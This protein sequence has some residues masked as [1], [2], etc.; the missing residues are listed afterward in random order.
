[1][2]EYRRICADIDLDAL[3]HNLDEIHRCISEG[4]K[5]IAVVKANG[6]GHG[7]VPLAEVMEK[8]ED[9]WGY[10][11]ATPEEAEELYTNGMK[12]PILILGYTF[13]EYDAQIVKEELRPAVFSLIRA[14]QLSEEALRQ[15]KI[16]KIHIKLDTG[17][18]RIGFQVTEQSADEIAQIAKLPHIMIEGIFTHF[19]KA[20]E[21]DKTFTKKQ[22][23]AYEQMITWLKER[24]VSI[25]VHHVS[26]S[27]GIVDLPEYNKDIVRAGIILYGL[28]PSDEVDKE[29]IDLQPL[30]S[31]K[32]HVV[33][34]KELE[35]GR[36]ISYGGTFEVEHPMRIATVPVGY[37]DGYPRSLSN[38]GYVLIHGKRAAICGRVCMD[39]MM[40][41][42][43]EIADV[44]PGDEVTIIG[45][46]GAECITLEELGDLSGRF[47]YEF[48]CDLNKRIPRVYVKQK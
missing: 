3:T 38:K 41:D 14:K 30:L 19:S 13:P 25:P 16:C 11:V 24:R 5:I 20:D 35:P 40:V 37:A 44:C 48:A 27:A 1:M 15:D 18:S 43:T 10:A 22:E 21:T 42:V 32:S 36:I 33:H 34:V 26:N 29:H 6:Y 45:R 31:L 9:I 23:T 39:Q 4:T 47:N 28:W 8:R 2:K 12:K 46:D 17:M 7:A